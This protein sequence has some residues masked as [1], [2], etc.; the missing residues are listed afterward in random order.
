MLYHTLMSWFYLLPVIAGPLHHPQS[1]TFIF[2]LLSKSLLYIR[3]SYFYG[4][5]LPPL[6]V[7]LFCYLL[8]PIR[9]NFATLKMF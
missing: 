8:L 3:I 6:L 5:L 9:P 2:P 1:S 7:S 4:H